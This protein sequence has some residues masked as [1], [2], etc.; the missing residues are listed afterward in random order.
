MRVRSKYL[1]PQP[2]EQQYNSINRLN[3]EKVNIMTN[4]KNAPH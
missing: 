4:N 2:T 3:R 1:A